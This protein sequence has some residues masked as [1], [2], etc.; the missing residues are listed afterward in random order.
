MKF[1]PNKHYTTIAIYAII[2]LAV[3]ILFFQAVTNFSALLG[4]VKA[5]MQFI[6]PVVYGFVFAFL[7]N[8]MLR[9]YDNRLLGRLS[10]GRM[11]AKTRRGLGLLLTYITFFVIIFVFFRLVIPQ[12]VLSVENLFSQ[13]SSY[14]SALNNFYFSIIERLQNFEFFN[15]NAELQNLISSLNTKLTDSVEG[16]F[17]S[18]Y[19]YLTGIL[20][21]IFSAG[22]RLTTGIVNLFL[23]IVISIYFLSDREKLFAQSRKICTALF[24]ERASGLLYDIAQDANR[25]FNGFIIGKIIDSAIMGVLCFI[26]MSI[27]GWPFPVLISVII[28]ITNVIPYF[29]PFIGAIPSIFIILIVNPVQ[30]LLFTI[31]I[32]ILQQ[33]DG[34]IIGPKI[35]G[36]SIGLSALWVIFAIM[37]FSG[38]FGM[39]GMFIGVPLFALIYNMLKRLISY[40][41]TRKEK[42]TDTR[43]YDSP[44]N[45][46]IK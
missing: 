4:G 3:V 26:V 37:L 32:L 7:L 15:Q 35:L 29:G 8:P 21:Q 18:V 28:G 22:A 23:G 19:E 12:L 39:L 34:N 25:I 43:D 17:E 42:S 38:I 16:I 36:E 40:L 1:R 24:S 11:R 9:M 45:P 20:P 6:Q 41:L 27:A 14:I 44:E 33:I 13:F 2:V 5:V 30:A 10:Q 46:L 31:F